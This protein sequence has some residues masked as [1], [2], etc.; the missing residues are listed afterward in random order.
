MN[1][2]HLRA[3]NKLEH[4]VK[5]RMTRFVVRRVLSGILALFI[6]AT[7]TFFLMHLVPG[8]PF[9]AEKLSEKTIAIMEAK[10]GFNRPL[11]EQYFD[12]MG[13]LLKG[14]LG[15]SVKKIGYSVNEIIGERFPVSAKLGI[16][17]VLM[18]ILI[19][20]PL[21]TLAAMKRGKLPDRIVM[22][23]CTIGVSVPSFVVATLLLYFLGIKWQL[24]PTM[25]L[26]SPMHYIM[27]AIALALNPLS[28]IAR[29]TRSSLLDVIDQ[30]Y[31][32]TARAKGLN[33]FVVTFKHALRNSLIPVITYLGPLT[34][35]TLV[36]GFVV[37]KVFSIP[38]LGNYFIN[39]I[40]NRDYPLIMGTAIFYALVLIIANLVVDILYG[41][42][43]PRIKNN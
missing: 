20:I 24:L 6:V 26:D 4:E 27:P 16:V 9:N 36:G 14:D 7:L 41:I 25:R 37:E 8:G 43:D 19:G 5:T 23:T 15:I 12:Y 1:G 38:G 11:H 3:V 29:L 35:G 28:Y 2:R 17:S 31:I 13:N 33:R 18:A 42:V 39:S 34:A 32:K 21:G 40:N 30:D 22:F 10:Y